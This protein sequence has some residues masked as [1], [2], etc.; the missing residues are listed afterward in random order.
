MSTRVRDATSLS[1]RTA[2]IAGRVAL[3]VALL[4]MA[5]SVLRFM[6]GPP[7]QPSFRNYGIV[8]T[9]IG[10]ADVSCGGDT[11]EGCGD[12]TAIRFASCSPRWRDY[13]GVTS[14][15]VSDD[16]R[17]RRLLGKRPPSGNRWV[18][19]CGGGDAMIQGRP[20]ARLKPE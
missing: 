12:V 3:T 15:P 17:V 8:R 11:A 9:S 4:V 16:R 14:D 1:R 13:F 19:Y 5:A 10:V 2:R 20:L 6:F 18:V 7:L